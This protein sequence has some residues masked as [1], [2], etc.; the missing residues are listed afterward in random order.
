M[1]GGGDSQLGK[2]LAAAFSSST[3]PQLLD[4]AQFAAALQGTGWTPAML[5]YDGQPVSQIKVDA[6]P[7]TFSFDL[8]QVFQTVGVSYHGPS[9]GTITM[10]EFDAR[11]TTIWVWH[12]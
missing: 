6:P 3:G 11:G 4:A 1:P 10:S 12:H 7:V 5:G 9:M 2:G 8:A